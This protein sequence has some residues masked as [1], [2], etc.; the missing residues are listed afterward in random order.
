MT[1]QQ[2]V[3]YILFLL[4]FVFQKTQSKTLPVYTP[5][6]KLKLRTPVNVVWRTSTFHYTAPSLKNVFGYLSNLNQ[7]NWAKR[8]MFRVWPPG[9]LYVQL[10]VTLINLF[11]FYIPDFYMSVEYSPNH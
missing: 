1:L 8:I 7:S 9:S 6:Q 10:F 5:L 11:E 3:L 2:N 4:C